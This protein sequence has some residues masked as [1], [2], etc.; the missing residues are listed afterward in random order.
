MKDEGNTIFYMKDKIDKV[1]DANE[2]GGKIIAHSMDCSP[3]QEGGPLVNY[4]TGAVVGIFSGA[5]TL[6]DGTDY[7]VSVMV[8]SVFMDWFST[9]SW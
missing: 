8:D 1:D 6:G 7:Y 4:D 9:V 2:T 5:A 3:G